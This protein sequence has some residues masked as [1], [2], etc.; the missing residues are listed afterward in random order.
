MIVITAVLVSLLIIAA[1]QLKQP[2]MFVDGK[3]SNFKVYTE[4]VIIFLLACAII[5][6][7]H[8]RAVI[9]KN[10]LFCQQFFDTKVFRQTRQ[11]P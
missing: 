10:V 5:L 1:F 11:K 3:L 8:K 2:V 9:E 6:Y 4:F 7:W